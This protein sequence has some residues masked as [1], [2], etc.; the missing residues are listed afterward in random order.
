MSNQSSA[1]HAED[2]ENECE[3][4]VEEEE[5]EEED[6]H[7]KP[8]VASTQK[9]N[10]S[11]VSSTMFF[12]DGKPASSEIIRLNSDFTI[13]WTI[14]NEVKKTGVWISSMYSSSNQNAKWTTCVG[15]KWNGET[16]NEH[17][18]VSESGLLMIG[19][20]SFLTLQY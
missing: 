7:E 12:I 18:N 17:V 8:N 6:E 10:I 14:G 15:I 4:E 19:E 1:N 13:S 11:T 16:K 9:Q 3:E 20:K 5:E 2:Q